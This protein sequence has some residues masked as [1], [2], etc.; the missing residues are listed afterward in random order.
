MVGGAASGLAR[1][2]MGAIGQRLLHAL[3]RDSL[4]GALRLDLGAYERAPRGDLQARVVADVEALADAAVDLLPSL[5]VQAV[6]VAG[7][8]AALALLSPVCALV[9]LVAV[10]PVALA[11]RRLARRSAHV[12]PEQRA[13]LA[14]MTGHAVETLQAAAP[15]QSHGAEAR[16]LAAFETHNERVVTALLAGTRMRNRFYPAL[17]LVQAAAT[18][19]VVVIASLQALA[20]PMTVGTATAVVLALGGMYVPLV[21]L[22]G[23]L[24]DVLAARAAL[25]RVV[26]L[27]AIPEPAAG[28]AALPAHGTLAFE[29]VGFA[30]LPGRPVLAGVDLTI[31]P[32]ERL[33]LVG[34]T[35]SGKSTIAR[36]A[37]GLARP[38]TGR[39]RLGDVDLAD[40][41]EASRRR[42]LALLVQ[43]AFLVDGTIA[44]NVLLAAPHAGRDAVEAAVDRLAL[45]PWVASLPAGVASPAG[46]G[47][48][49]LSAGERQLVSLLRVVVADPAVVALDEATSLLDARTEALVA[50][51]L[52]RALR[53]RTVVIIA[54]RQ[55][56]AARCDR[57]G[58][59]AAGRLVAVGAH[60]ELMRER[61]D[62]RRLSRS[63]QRDR[64]LLEQVHRVLHA[65]LH[66]RS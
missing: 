38:G 29:R 30:Y 47:G 27:S 54:H 66:A 14:A 2:Q 55:A 52:D 63:A 58:L 9:A 7:G 19:L 37:V 50:A 18:A 13:S 43:A 33:G 6:A 57:V 44:D 45:R 61:P 8:F 60:A 31:A 32:G 26:E 12:Y 24:D 20:G 59:V 49:A 40:A 25:V 46:P 3:R 15:L 34:A 42:R 22:V 48:A 5:A 65:G 35:G 53:G 10:A 51:A 16:R 1:A 21:L 17:T 64:D 28:A 56:T 41:S 36:L 11:G 39:V 23:R 4:A 62:Y